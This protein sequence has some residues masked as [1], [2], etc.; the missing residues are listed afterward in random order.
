MKYV[1]ATV[2]FSRLLPVIRAFI[3]FPAGVVRM[4][5]LKFHVHTFAG[6]LPWCLAL[7]YAGL[8]LGERWDSLRVYFH[9]MDLVLGIV[10]VAG[11]IY[12]VER[13]LRNR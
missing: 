4:N 10:I 13:H 8:K 2:F 7:A 12:F 3:T 9:R 6:S 1:D 11:V 5:L